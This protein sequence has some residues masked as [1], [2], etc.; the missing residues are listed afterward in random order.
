MRGLNQ[1]M[2]QGNARGNATHKGILH[3]GVCS[4]QGAGGYYTCAA[5]PCSTHNEARLARR[6]TECRCC[7]WTGGAPRRCPQTG[8][9]C[10]RGGS[11][12]DP[13]DRWRLQKTR[14]PALTAGHRRQHARRP[15][16]WQAWMLNKSAACQDPHSTESGGRASKRQGAQNST[17]ISTARWQTG[18]ES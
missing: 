9:C 17:G 3:A 14:P 11:E 15:A 7:R 6:R 13:R 4:L 5:G 2:G 1:A 16:A 8:R 10:C 18:Q 12:A